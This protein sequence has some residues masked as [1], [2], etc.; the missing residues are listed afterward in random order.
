MAKIR[1]KFPLG[2]LPLFVWAD[3]K[4]PS[5]KL[6]LRASILRHRHNLSRAYAQVLDNEMT[7]GTK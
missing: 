5:H 2:K 4:L 3:T 1:Q 7:G 6:T